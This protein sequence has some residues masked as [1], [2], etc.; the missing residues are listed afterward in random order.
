M[1]PP[2]EEHEQ[3]AFPER[4]ILLNEKF[5]VHSY[6]GGA[7]KSR[8]Q[9]DVKNSLIPIIEPFHCSG[10]GTKF[11]LVLKC[12][13][14]FTLSHFYVSGPGPR[15]T[16]PIRSGL[17]WVTD[18]PP[19]AEGLK[20]YDAMSSEEL[21]E[22]VK[23]LRTYSSSE[24]AGSVPDPCVYF[25]T[26]PTSRESEVELPKWK[27]GR[28]ISVKF[29]DT[30]KDGV[31]MDVGI[32]GMIGYLGR[33]GK[34]QV[35]LGPWMRRSARQ[36][37]VHPNELKSMFS[38]SGWVCDG[39]DF[40]GGCRSGQTDFHQTNVYTAT[41]RCTTSGFDLC[42]KCAFD[43][44]V[45]RVT[46]KSIQADLE[47]LGDTSSCKLAATRLRNLCRRNWF[48]ALP[49]YIDA[50]LLD[51]L[52][53]ILQKCTDSSN[54]KPEEE[55][56]TAQ[57]QQPGVENK[58]RQIRR[59]LL[60]LTTE[61]TQRL[62]GLGCGGDV[63]SNDLVWAFRAD[64]RGKEQ[65][66]EGRVV[67]LPK[68]LGDTLTSRPSP[69]PPG[70]LSSAFLLIGRSPA[71]AS[72]PLGEDPTL[73]VAGEE[74]ADAVVVA[75]G[76]AA[77]GSGEAVPVAADLP[78]ELPDA[79]DTSSAQKSDESEKGT[80]QAESCYYITWR[81]GQASSW[82]SP[83]HCWRMTADEDV[84]MSTAGLFLELAN[85]PSCDAGKVTKLLEQGA[86]L[87][88]VNGEGCTALLLAVRAE[89]P[90][91]AVTALLEAGACP[92]A[93]G[94]EGVTP[95][96]LVLR[97]QQG[98]GRGSQE[99]LTQYAEALKG[100]GATLTESKADHEERVLSLRR[101]YGLKMVGALLTLQSPLLL[102]VEVLEILHL[103][104][105]DLP[106]TVLKESLQLQ[107]FRALTALLQHLVGGTDNV[108]VA[109]VGC[110]IMQALCSQPDPTLR[111]LVRSHGAKRWAER[112]STSKDIAQCG[113]Y[114]QP[115][116]EK[117]P[118]EELRREAQALHQEL[119]KEETPSEG[120]AQDAEAWRSNATLREVVR[121]L[122]GASEPTPGR[123]APAEG[124]FALRDILKNTEQ[125]SI[126]DERCSAFEL[127]SAAVPKRL[128]QY[129]KY[130]APPA[131]GNLLCHP[132]VNPER[133]DCFNEAF[134]DTSKQS[135]KGLARLMKALH[136]V[137]ETGEAL[138]IWRYKK[139]RGLKA[140]TETIPL[141]LHNLPSPGDQHAAL[142]IHLPKTAQACLAVMIEPLVPLAELSRY[143]MKVTPCLDVQYVAY[144]HRLVG[145][146][147]QDL[148]SGNLFQ[149]ESVEMLSS[150][151]PLL[152]HTVRPVAGG[153]SQRWLLAARSYLLAGT[154]LQPASDVEHL[155]LKVALNQLQAT[156]SSEAYPGQVDK[157]IGELGGASLLKADVPE[158]AASAP[159]ATSANGPS[160]E[161]N[162]GTTP[163]LLSN[164]LSEAAFQ[165]ALLAAASEASVEDALLVLA[166]EMSRLSGTPGAAAEAEAE[167]AVDPSMRVHQVMIAV[168]DEIPFE[169]FWPM[170]R[171]DI[172]GAAREL[173]PRGTQQSEEA[174]QAGVAQ[175]G[176]GP[177]AQKLTLR[178]AEGLAGRVGHVVQTAVTVDAQ[179][180]EDLK[181]EKA[182][183]Q[184]SSS[185]PVASRVQFSAVGDSWI[186]GTLVGQSG[187]R[188]TLVDEK[189][190]VW[191]L[192]QTRV[193]L[194]AARRESMNSMGAPVQAVLTQADLV[195]IR[196]HLRRRQEEFT[197]RHA[198]GIAGGA[199]AGGI[200]GLSALGG[201]GDA[202]FAAAGAMLENRV[203]SS[204]SRPPSGG[205][206]AVPQ[207]PRA[208]SAPSIDAASRPG[209]HSMLAR[210]ASQGE[211]P[212]RSFEA[213]QFMDDD[214]IGD[215]DFDDEGDFGPGDEGDEDEEDMPLE[216]DE[217]SMMPPLRLGIGGGGYGDGDP[218]MAAMEEEMRVLEQLRAMEQIISEVLEPQDG[219]SGRR[220]SADAGDDFPGPMAGLRI[221]MGGGAGETF[222]IRRGGGSA[223]ARAGPPTEPLRAEFPAFVRAADSTNATSTLDHP[224]VERLGVAELACTEESSEQG[225]GTDDPMQPMG[226]G[227]AAPQICVRFCL[228]PIKKDPA[229][230]ESDAAA[231]VSSSSAENGSIPLPLPATAAPVSQAVP[232]QFPRSWNLLKVMQFL[233][234]QQL[235]SSLVDASLVAD[236]AEAPSCI[237]LQPLQKV[238]LDNWCLGYQLVSEF[239]AGLDDVSGMADA[240]RGA[241]MDVDASAP[242]SPCRRRGTEDSSAPSLQHG[243]SSASCSSGLP[244][245]KRR[246]TLPA[247][248]ISDAVAREM[249]SRFPAVASAEGSEGSNAQGI[250]QLISKCG[251]NSTV[252]DAIELLHLLNSRA[253]SL[254]TEATSWVSSKLDRKLRYQLE[255]PLS[256]I[257]GTLPLW[258]VTLPRLCPFLFSLKTRK[259]LLK[260]TAFGPSFAV[261]WTQ[262]S[263]VGSLLKRRATIQ[264]ELNAATE[265]RKMQ[266]LSQ[267]LS[268]I[269]EHVVRST[270]WLGTLQSTLVR[271]SKGDDLLRQ[272]DVAMELLSNSSKLLEVQFDGETGFGI[273]VTQSFYVEVAQALQERSVNHSIPMWVGDDN[274]GEGSPHLLCRKGLLLRPLPPGAQRDLAARRFRFLGRLMGQ[275]LREG[276][277]VPLPLAE[278]FFALV[279]DEK[280]G[281]S[282]LPLPGSGCAGELVGALALFAA[283]LAAGEA[284][285]IAEGRGSVDELQAWRNEQAERSDFAERFLTA[286]VGVNDVSSAQDPTSFKEYMEMVGACF[287]ETGLS[288]APLCPEGDTVALT[289]HNVQDFAE[290]AASFWFDTGV[291]VQL[292]AFRAG[293]NDVF[294]VDCLLSFDR[295]ELR[296]MFCGEDRIEWDE[297]SLLNH[298]HPTGGLTEKSPTYRFLVAVLVDLTQEERSRFLDFVTSCPRLPPGGM[299]KFHVDI[300]P[301]SSATK[302][303]FP[304]SRACANQLYLPPYT[305]KEELQEKL[306][307]AMH[308]SAGHHEQ[309]VVR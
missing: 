309:R 233:H 278:E 265:A 46:D 14:D 54:Q 182:K 283:D 154:S 125:G 280:L 156:T 274:A 170:V 36:I 237:L 137:I 142:E 239:P 82:V 147:I 171:D 103:L 178:E 159:A 252:T 222:Q 98:E 212:A 157:L 113:L 155:Q 207:R 232:I 195:R 39:R 231:V 209:G 163:A 307:E 240:S 99:Q 185:I 62:L 149:V 180:V 241:A 234:D 53:Q 308:S 249:Y 141:K 47:A 13:E 297:Q 86:D 74:S 153:E 188:F 306:H 300:F 193:R 72:K 299:A 27:E 106:V 20:K 215:E 162:D 292:E 246:R 19:D 80:P 272:S 273:A 216:G 138:P 67:Q 128:M 38:S 276:F 244:A 152:L 260:Y 48:E 133:W 96:E 120:E 23:G 282:S 224:V 196:E 194:P 9:Y 145:A 183:T 205:A 214:G 204:S 16:E 208:S 199:S 298:M 226:E 109:L 37:W 107:A 114:R 179:A 287:L 172:L 177:I 261:H 243:S 173:C 190:V 168:S 117:V 305:S 127:E 42:E 79:E 5:K 21:M 189:G 164:A 228:Q 144:C 94:R 197:Q 70:A 236:A 284:A 230:S 45:G 58:K 29:L 10:S 61:L 73:P 235:R 293:F 245:K 247:G 279:L 12:S 95:L 121:A 2:L 256:V 134:G 174:I 87:M 238:P 218:G 1:A 192:A 41:F 266:E 161:V 169:L 104:L 118:T 76:E 77:S 85:G 108:S 303:G 257:S 28:Y 277:I 91:D 93:S 119:L 253:P 304:R 158:A 143:L 294:P 285:A 176:M 140:L 132:A 181:R 198:Q 206:D 150:G 248:E 65:W 88:A 146:K 55:R 201:A 167:P 242:G 75:S 288:G 203:P 31:N 268:N 59:S 18:Q 219:R 191:D 160:E 165:A 262:E 221:R 92:D 123:M 200:V 63:A 269:E 24:D 271:F 6:D 184:S 116:H 270:F 281:P 166:Q 89:V 296:E 258:A 229:A 30:H 4:P 225:A 139:E 223:G 49:R 64:A 255:D 131:V 56:A 32:L 210:L 130:Q 202:S 115:S 151:L 7:F 69:P 186:P 57:R 251:D 60:Q 187:D 259:M 15:C 135:R 22:I 84:M 254:N 40:T 295:S 102:P 101:A 129:L 286:Q 264:T 263:K 211:A 66:D 148:V 44:S 11:C 301:D 83:Q 51:T 124:L 105:R 289:V 290:K 250:E 25:T 71:A 220:A 217:E 26:D 33:H 43:P 81:D 267:E 110:R 136:A 100:H 52:I 17:V 97:F 78:P 68:S 126:S 122:E 3:P 213:V 111:Y 90:V 112:L 302:Q 8:A 227:R 50:G 34:M 175:N 275:A 291:S 35:P